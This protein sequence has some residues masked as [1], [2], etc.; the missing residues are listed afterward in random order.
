MKEGAVT[1]QN[2]IQVAC[3]TAMPHHFH[4]LSASFAEGYVVCDLETDLRLILHVI[5]KEQ[6]LFH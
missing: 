6:T 5:L 2:S 4:L 1:L 3:D